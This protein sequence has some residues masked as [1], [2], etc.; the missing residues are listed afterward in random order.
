VLGFGKD[1]EILKTL[2]FDVLVKHSIDKMSE[3]KRIFSPFISGGGLVFLLDPAEVAERFAEFPRVLMVPTQWHGDIEE[4]ILS[5]SPIRQFTPPDNGTPLSI[6]L[7]THRPDLLSGFDSTT[8]VIKKGDLYSRAVLSAAIIATVPQ[9]EQ[10][11]TRLIEN[12]GSTGIVNGIALGL[13]VAQGPRPLPEAESKRLVNVLSSF[14]RGG[15]HGDTEKSIVAT[16][17]D[18]ID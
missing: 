6:I 1:A 10:T 8:G 4:V 5:A 7:N 16:L 3:E 13:F 14:Y 12:F 18:L 17:E 9:A 15:P 11:L 2:E